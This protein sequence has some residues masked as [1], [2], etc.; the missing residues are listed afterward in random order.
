MGY[1]EFANY[2][3]KMSDY[4][5]G[6]W[7]KTWTALYWNFVSRHVETFQNNHR[8]SMMPKTLERMK[9]GTR[10]DHFERAQSFL[11]NL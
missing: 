6:D 2:I 3:K 11:N 7:E 8:L 5:S 1:I 10:Q 4:E 9:E